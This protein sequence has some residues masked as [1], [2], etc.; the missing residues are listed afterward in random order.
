MVVSPITRRSVARWLHSWPL[1]LFA[2]WS[3]LSGASAPTPPV[4]LKMQKIPQASGWGV[5]R[6]TLVQ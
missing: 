2:I 6:M 5:S 3:Q 1:S 4:W